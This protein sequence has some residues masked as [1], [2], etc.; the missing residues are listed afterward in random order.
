[1]RTVRICALFITILASLTLA[2]CWG[3]R[4]SDGIAYV[5]AVGFDKGEKD[6]L[7]VT[8]GI[9][10]P[11]TLVG[12]GGGGAGGESEK[13]IVVYSVETY[14][15]LAMPNLLN[16]T[17]D[18]PLSL[19]HAKAF[20]FSEE[21]AREGLGKWLL[22][23]IRNREV[24]GTSQIFIS[25]GKAREFIENNNPFLT[26]SPAKQYDL[27]Y[28]LSDEHGL[29]SS[30][31]L[32]QFY[33]Y[34]KSEAIEATA[35]LVGVHLGELE[36]A[37]PGVAKGGDIALGKYVAGEVP[38]AGRN[39]AQF[40]GTAVFRHDKMLGTLNGQESRYYLMIRG[41]FGNGVTSVADPLSEDS[42]FV[43]FRV[44]QAR[45]PEYKVNIDEDGKVSIDI[46]IFLEPEIIAYTGVNS[47]ARSDLK[48]IY[49]EAFSKYIEQGCNTL[50]KRTQEEFRSDIF[51]FGQHLT[52]RFWTVQD[53]E[54][55]NWLHRYPDAEINVAVH[56]HIRRTGLI[57]KII[58]WKTE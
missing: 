29:Y 1:M 16:T 19:L 22:P 41:L 40:I 43:G 56:S 17:I 27:I 55:F 13:N 47:I 5:L 37:K 10:N 21:L 20:V 26:I 51:G 2:G 36:S 4:E 45:D 3:S 23:L 35:P 50:I 11:R 24:R 42:A 30:I 49:E 32:T 58:P 54:E 15:P 53:W 6:S 46:D 48:P 38:V 52:H 25:R 18:R 14:A 7:V 28:E 8:V 57:M 31:Q 12:G 44:Q 39:K 9:A 34:L 33:D